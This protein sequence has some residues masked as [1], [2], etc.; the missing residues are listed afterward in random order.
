MK[1]PIL[2]INLILT[3]FRLNRNWLS[4]Y[5]IYLL[6]VWL[7]AAIRYRYVWITGDDP[8]LLVQGML[9]RNNLQPNFDFV[10]GYPGLGQFVYSFFLTVF[11]KSIFTQHI[12]TAVIASLLGLILALTLRNLPVTINGS[13]L[14]FTYHQQHAVNPT[15]NPGFLSEI[16]FLLGYIFFLKD[17]QCKSSSKRLVFSGVMFGISFLAKQYALV[18]LP[19]AF[20]YFYS[21]IKISSRYFAIIRYSIISFT[22]LSFGLGYFLVLIP[23]QSR[24]MALENLLLL[25]IPFAL[26]VLNMNKF[27]GGEQINLSQAIKRLTH[28]Y[29]SFI[30]TIS[31]GLVLMYRNLHLPFL[32]N[33]VL[34]VAPKRIN[35][36]VGQIQFSSSYIIQ[37]ISTI[38]FLAIVLI[39]FMNSSRKYGNIYSVIL[40]HFLLISIAVITFSYIG[41]LSSTV[42]LVL[43]S[44]VLEYFI[45][46]RIVIYEKAVVLMLVVAI[47][48]YV[49]IPYPNI[50]FHVSFLVLILGFVFQQFNLRQKSNQHYL[51]QITFPFLLAI[52]LLVHQINFV[53]SLQVYRFENISFVSPDLGWKAEIDKAKIINGGY[54]D[55]DSNA[56]KMLILLIQK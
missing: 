47:Y 28:I 48:L 49:L 33:E 23:D 27:G 3:Y 30:L 21:K 52:A 32:V 10:S 25:T 29:L 1:E 16:F 54:Q 12:Y 34:I 26:F 45:F 7:F 20:I 37:T 8:N 39:I 6:L 15:P 41:N 46:K 42:F 31:L 55:C 35:Q 9:T 5:S 36:Y 51:L 22:G 4:A 18:I 11:G 38:M 24:Y 17:S 56:C 19:I 13:L 43:P 14:I 40:S 50:N 53:N 2:N 44:I